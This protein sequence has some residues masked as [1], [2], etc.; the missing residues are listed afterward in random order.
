MKVQPRWRAKLSL[1][2]YVAVV[3]G[4]F[5]GGT[6]VSLVLL[7]V[8]IDV[9]DPPFP[10]VLVIIPV[11]EAII[12]GVTLLF[13]RY[14]RGGLGELGLRKAS[15]KTAMIALI[16][17]LPLWLLGVGISLGEVMIFG[18][19]P[20]AE[21]MDRAMMPRNSL[22]AVVMVV[23]SMA[24]VGPCEELW[25]R[26][27]VQR[28]FENS[29]GKTKGLLIASALFGLAHSLN[30]L[31]AIIPTFVVGLALG[32]TWQRTNGNTTAIAIMHGAI[33]SVSFS[34]SYL[35]GLG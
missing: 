21:L 13:A 5:V 8:G 22:Q 29:F 23:Y 19:D 20:V 25:A 7:S 30:T 14:R 33:D 27:F 3:A 28:G 17:A 15:A 2:C 26:G 4:T 24:L 11:N 12:V 35:L 18:P 31:Y 1:L 9:V 34:V 10:T 32:Y 16:A 6:V